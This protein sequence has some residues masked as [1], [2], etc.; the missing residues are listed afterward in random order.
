MCEISKIDNERLKFL[1]VR[2][3]FLNKIMNAETH[4]VNNII[5]FIYLDELL[6]RKIRIGKKKPN[7]NT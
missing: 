3:V 7:N 4:G 6:M 1:D 5:I 2:N